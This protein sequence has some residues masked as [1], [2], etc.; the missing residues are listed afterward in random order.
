MFTICDHRKYRF[1]LFAYALRTWQEWKANMIQLLFTTQ[2]LEVNVLEL[3]CSV[4]VS[5]A[6]VAFP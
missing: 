5:F 3:K 4:T 6:A 2:S 1:Q